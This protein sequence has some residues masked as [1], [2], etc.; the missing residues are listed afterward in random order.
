MDTRIPILPLPEVEDG[1]G[2]T[3][4]S[5]IVHKSEIIPEIKIG[6]GAYELERDQLRHTVKKS[7]NPYISIYTRSPSQ[8][9]V[10]RVDVK[11]MLTI[12]RRGN[13][14]RACRLRVDVAKCERKFLESR[15]RHIC[16]K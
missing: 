5:R 8:H 3:C 7:P 6:A 14:N 1:T 15:S 2:A 4:D 10:Q 13:R 11:Q 16:Q 9:V 12:D